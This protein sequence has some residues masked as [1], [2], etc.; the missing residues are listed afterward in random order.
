MYTLIEFI[1]Q[2]ADRKNATTMII[3]EWYEGEDVIDEEYC[4]EGTPSE[5]IDKYCND[6]DCIDGFDVFDVNELEVTNKG[7]RSRVYIKIV[8]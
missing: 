8:K 2:F 7:I 3:L 5:F 4:F 1:R 6:Y